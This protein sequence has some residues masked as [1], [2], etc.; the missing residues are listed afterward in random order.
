MALPPP[1][2]RLEGALFADA[3]IAAIFADE[4]RIVRMLAVEAALARAQACRGLIPAEAVASI[5]RAASTPP[6]P[7]DLAEGTVAAGVPVPALVAKARAAAGP[8]GAWLHRGATSQDILDTALTLGLRH[9]LGRLLARLDALVRALVA[10]AVRDAETPMAGRT[11]TQIATPTTFGLRVSAWLGPL[12]RHRQRL[13]ELAPRVLVVQLGGA[14]G[15]QS[16]LG[17]EAPELAADLARELGLFAPPKPWCSERDGLAETGAWCSL[18]AG[19]C[20]KIGADL[21][22]AARSEIAEIRAGTGGGSST[23]PQKANPVLAETLVTLARKTAGD[24]GTLHLAL[25]HAEERDTT[26]W[27]LEWLILPGMLAATGAALSHATALV[28]TLEPDRE[29]MRATLD[30]TGGAVLAEGFAF[31]LAE[32][33]PLPE[34]QALVKQALGLGGPL[35]E[36]L[37]ALTDVP[38]DWAALSAYEAHT[39][40]AARLVAATVAAA[41]DALVA[42]VPGL[43]SPA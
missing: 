15:N 2:S 35:A 43:A 8:A 34:A 5:A 24:L 21:A 16:A 32:H 14:S 38:L 30:A 22:L 25:V 27:A 31:A 9:A 19:A 10:V 28:E 37:A 18:V 29:R 13:A 1:V 3:E 39:G 33:M 17:P 6:R 4:A 20:G 42:P 7:E 11:R 26:A 12:L 23:M 36:R 41:E 40:S